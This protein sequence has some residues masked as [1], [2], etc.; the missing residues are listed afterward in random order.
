[1]RT[2]TNDHVSCNVREALCPKN[3]GKISHVN[4]M[5]FSSWIDEM[6]PF[7]FAFYYKLFT[8]NITFQNFAYFVLEFLFSFIIIFEKSTEYL[9]SSH[10]LNQSIEIR[11]KTKSIFFQNMFMDIWRTPKEPLTVSHK[12][13]YLRLY[14]VIPQTPKTNNANYLELNK[15]PHYSALLWDWVHIEKT[16]FSTPHAYSGPHAYFS[17]G[18]CLPNMLIWDHMAN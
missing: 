14:L 11:M 15:G 3:D 13:T 10:N 12:S 7:N 17:C 1:M 16:N 6:C 4:G 18:R 8:A 9:F 5:L 2:F